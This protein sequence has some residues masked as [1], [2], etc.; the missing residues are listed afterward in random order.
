[1]ERNQP[2]SRRLLTIERLQGWSMLAY[3]PLEHIYFLASQN[4][5]KLSDKTITKIA[6]WSCRFWAAYVI[7]QFYHLREDSRILSRRAKGLKGSEI[8][9]EQ[10]D[11]VLSRK[12]A[13]LNELWVN[14]GYMPLTIHWSLEQGLYRN[15][16]SAAT[17]YRTCIHISDK[18]FAVLDWALRNDCRLCK[19]PRWLG[20]YRHEVRC[21]PIRNS[22][23]DMQYV[24]NIYF[25]FGPVVLDST[26]FYPIVCCGHFDVRS[27]CLSKII[28]SATSSSVFLNVSNGLFMMLHLL[29]H[30]RVCKLSRR[31]SI[32]L[33]AVCDAGSASYVL[34][35]GVGS[36]GD[37][38]EFDTKPWVI[39]LSKIST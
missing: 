17:L 30:K 37:H 23:R 6:V 13:L 1:M 2:P 16:V 4:I 24:D 3:Y 28:R 11:E 22:C 20:G 19:L 39:G 31:V 29:L 7:L 26:R 5:I 15:E 35:E 9:E 38:F 27:S 25:L 36:R 10:R 12:R 21:L 8:S 14:I 33:M 34:S 32:Y 18:Y